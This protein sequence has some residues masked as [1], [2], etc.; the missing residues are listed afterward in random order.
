MTTTSYQENW[1]TPFAPLVFFLPWFQRYGVTIDN[2]N[3][4]FGY[5]YRG[6]GGLTAQSIPIENIDKSSIVVGNASWWDNL[7]L[8]GGWGIR[9]G[10]LRGN[11]IWAYNAANG[12]YVELSDRAGH[13]FRFVS[14]DVEK[15]KQILKE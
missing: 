10:F 8:F 6:P 13:R 1:R 7:A 14:H 3:L 9:W 15:V 4:T 5:G 11:D 2:Q 12:P